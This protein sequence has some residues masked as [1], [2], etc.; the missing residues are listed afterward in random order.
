MIAN[1]C[2]FDDAKNET[3]VTKFQKWVYIFKNMYIQENNKE[4]AGT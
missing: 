2:E 1:R 4:N 3:V